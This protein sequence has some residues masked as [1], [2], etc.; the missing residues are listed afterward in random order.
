MLI[1]LWWSAPMKRHLLYS[2]HWL[3]EWTVDY[4]MVFD[5][6]VSKYDPRFHSWLRQYEPMNGS[7]T[8]PL[9]SPWWYP[10][11]VN[12]NWYFP[13][14]RLYKLQCHSI[15]FILVS[16]FM[17]K[18]SFCNALL[19]NYKNPTIYIYKNTAEWLMCCWF[20]KQIYF[21]FNK[22]LMVYVRKK[23][24]IF[25]IGM[26]PPFVPIIIVEFTWLRVFF[27]FTDLKVYKF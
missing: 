6:Y 14:P 22:I 17:R 1:Y 9:T 19:M 25:F 2:T 4:R 20:F 11:T 27:L 10:I 5:A 3:I 16:I 12:W 26:F 23:F 21:Y 15:Y 13:S 24:L 18:Q 8:L 7:V